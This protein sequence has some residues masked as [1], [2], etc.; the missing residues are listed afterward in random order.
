M[1]SALVEK[2]RVLQLLI[3]STGGFLYPG[4]RAELRVGIQLWLETRHERPRGSCPLGTRRDGKR[5]LLL[6]PSKR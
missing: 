2:V 5:L 4:R 6:L 1:G 3:R